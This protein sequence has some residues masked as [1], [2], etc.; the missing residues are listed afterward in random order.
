MLVNN[1][2]IAEFEAK[3]NIFNKYFASQRTTI[4]NNSVILSTLNH[5]NDDKLSSCNILSE[6]ISQLSLDPNK[7]HGHDE[8][9]VKM[10]KLCAPS[11][12]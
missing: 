4:N 12:C 8:I 9:S 5:L 11:I 2:V 6:V 3:A 10:L 7:G 1:E